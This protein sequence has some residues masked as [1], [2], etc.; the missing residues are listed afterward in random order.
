MKLGTGCRKS[1][2]DGTELK[3][4]VPLK[5]IPQ[6]YSW[7][8]NMP[9][10]LD[11]G[12]TPKCVAYSVAS[13]LD[14]RKNLREGDNN[15]GQFN[16]NTI[17]DCRKDKNVDGMSIKEAL[18]FIKNTGVNGYKIK[19]FAMVGSLEVL[20]R[21][22]ISNGPCLAA[23]MVKSSNPDFWNG[24]EMLG[25]H[26]I[27]IVGYNKNGFILRNSWGIS[28]GKHG[29]TLLLYK[30]FRQLFEIWTIL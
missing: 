5:P 1:V 2:L 18:S 12:Q 29:Y 26:C 23:M 22:I 11:Q 19:G 17:Y 13:V 27:T 21:A 8:R 24:S 14:W 9:P 30:D 28:W 10:I 6:E 20:K 7:I 3:Y 16:I 15:G 4:S 25:G